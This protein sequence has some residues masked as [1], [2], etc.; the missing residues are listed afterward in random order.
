MT[1]DEGLSKTTQAAAVSFL[2]G[3]TILIFC[4]IIQKITAG[5]NPYLL[6]AYIVPFFY[7]GIVGSLLGTKCMKVRMLNKVL[8]ER[9]NVLED[10]LP[11]CSHCRDIREPGKDPKDKNSW[12]PVDDYISKKTTIQFTHSICPDCMKEVYPELAAGISWWSD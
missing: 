12:H 11:I 4:S 5:F 7:G 3:S 8:A 1:K 2:C 9:N 10:F 6:K